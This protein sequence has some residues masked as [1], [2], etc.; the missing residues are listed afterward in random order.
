MTAT[1][2]LVIGTR[3]SRLARI[4]T[5]IVLALLK[6]V[7]QAS[8]PDF[9]LRGAEGIPVEVRVVHTEGDRTQ[10]QNTPLDQ[11]PRGVFVKELESALLDGSI[12][13]AVH[14][15][16]DMTT[17]QDPRLTI[18]AI[19]EREDPRDVMVGVR[20]VDLPPGAR[21]GTG[22]PRRTAQLRSV[23]PDLRFESIRG[24]VDTRVR[25]V[26]EGEFNAVVL[27]AAGLTRLGLKERIAEY[28]EPDVCLPDPG[29]GALAVQVRASD[30]ALIDLL[31]SLNHAPTWAAVIAERALLR[32]LGGGCK[33]PIG[34]LGV[35]D[36]DRLTL[37]GVIDT[38][39]ASLS[40]PAGDPEALGVALARELS[41]H[42][43]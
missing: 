30:T 31:A 18:A 9:T 17:E 8:S 10:A 29:Q 37:Y 24:N 40:G 19:P 6:H 32:E 15:L 16:K 12:D 1:R 4:Q 13:I 5:D 41:R 23:R 26:E 33:V 36:R 39:R 21:V 27:A 7:G 2:A 11:L 34:A 14:S 43:G 3:G 20:L 38:V 42:A 35:V 25:K 22:S 28:F